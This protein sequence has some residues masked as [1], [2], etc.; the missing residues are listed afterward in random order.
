MRK[1]VVFAL[2]LASPALADGPPGPPTVTLTQE[3]F[4]SIINAEVM[5]AVANVEATKAKA[6]YAKVNSA[7]SPPKPEPMPGGA[8]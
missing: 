6:A 1:F 3:E 4:Q 7:F 2:L 8:K 5:K